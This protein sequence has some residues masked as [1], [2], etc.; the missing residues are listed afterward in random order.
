MTGTQSVLQGLGDFEFSVH[1]DNFNGMDGC[2]V[3]S[4]SVQKVSKTFLKG[5]EE[6]GVNYVYP[7]DRI[8]P[9]G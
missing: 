1:K 6:K 3:D 2:R 8:N 9:I 4:E 5:G 7:G